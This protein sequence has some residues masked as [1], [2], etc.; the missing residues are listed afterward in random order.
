MMRR[1]R[2]DS[3]TPTNYN[4]DRIIYITRSR[5]FYITWIWIRKPWEIGPFSRYH[6]YESAYRV[7]DKQ[8]SRFSLDRAYV[9]FH[10]RSSAKLLEKYLSLPWYRRHSVH[11]NACQLERMFQSCVWSSTVDATFSVKVLVMRT[12]SASGWTH[13]SRVHTPHNW[14]AVFPMRIPQMC[15]ITE[16]IEP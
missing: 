3:L 15:Y 7:K 16:A 11:L 1:W 10:R 8:Y 2:R 12:Q 6:L 14:F 4:A 5:W 13:G 9:P